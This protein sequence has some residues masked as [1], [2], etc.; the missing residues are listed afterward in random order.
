MGAQHYQ[1]QA[2][3]AITA[4]F[5]E[6]GTLS[7]YKHDEVIKGVCNMRVDFDLALNLEPR[8]ARSSDVDGR[9]S[10]EDDLR[11]F[12]IDGPGGER[13]A[14]VAVADP[15]SVWYQAFRVSTSLIFPRIVTDG[16]PASNQLR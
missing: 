4:F 6:A 1:L 10:P 7:Y 11:T 15:H 3:R 12:E 16:K 9:P 13:I 8:F 5:T 2:V 14:E